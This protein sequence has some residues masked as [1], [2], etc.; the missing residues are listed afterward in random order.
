[1]CLLRFNFILGF[2]VLFCF[3]SGCVCMCV[4]DNEFETKEIKI[5]LCVIRNY[6]QIVP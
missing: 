6:D 5:E 3:V 1:M 2:K 4:Y